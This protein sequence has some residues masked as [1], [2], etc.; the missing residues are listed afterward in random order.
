M[1]VPEGAE[2][3]SNESSVV[4][5]SLGEMAELVQLYTVEVQ[6]GGGRE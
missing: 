2:V 5:V 3:V 4:T 1:E 6:L